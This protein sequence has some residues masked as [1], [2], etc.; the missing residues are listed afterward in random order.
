MVCDNVFDPGPHD[1][2]GV[3][4]AVRRDSITTAEG[5]V[6]NVSLLFERKRNSRIRGYVRIPNGYRYMPKG[7]LRQT[8]LDS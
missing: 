7:E 2:M 8:R 5:N 3:V 4:L 1:H 6:N